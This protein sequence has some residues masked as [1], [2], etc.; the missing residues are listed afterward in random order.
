V[1]PGGARLIGNVIRHWTLACSMDGAVLQRAAVFVLMLTLS[2]FLFPALAFALAY[3]GVHFIV[4]LLFFWPQF[5]LLPNGFVNNDIGPSQAYFMD[6]A[7]F[8]AVIF[9]LIFS[10]A[11]GYVLRTVKIRYVVLASYPVA[12]VTMIAFQS[13]LG[14]FG[15]STYLDGP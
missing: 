6:T 7:I 14:F 3:V 15:Y 2:V 10:A 8:G 11:C 9:W 13:V 4:N 12:L 1:G 5:M